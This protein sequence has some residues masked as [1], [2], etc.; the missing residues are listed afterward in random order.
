[1]FMITNQIFVVSRSTSNE[2]LAQHGPSVPRRKGD[3]PI[4][5][6]IDR[7]LHPALIHWEIGSFPGHYVPGHWLFALHALFHTVSRFFIRFH[8]DR[9]NRLQFRIFRTFHLQ[10][11]FWTGSSPA[12][13]RNS[14][15]RCRSIQPSPFTFNGP[16][17]PWAATALHVKNL[18]LTRISRL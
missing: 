6:A 8:R 11:N 1:M 2:S 10:R 5:A 7:L 3:H 9:R 12:N 18:E 15:P 4:F 13:F 17:F 16:I 14:R